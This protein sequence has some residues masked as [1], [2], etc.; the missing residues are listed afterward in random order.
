M[1]L[2]AL[3]EAMREE[4]SPRPKIHPEGQIARM[5][6]LAPRFTAPCPFKVG[7]LVTPRKDGLVKGPGDPCLIVQI[8]N[9]GTEPDFRV[10]ETDSPTYGAIPDIRIIRAAE[11]GNCVSFWS[12][13]TEYDLYTGEGAGA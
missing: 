12:Y 3:L 13:S 4:E 7:D 2:S 9:A 5:R 10:G 1:S 8:N 11:S 6:E